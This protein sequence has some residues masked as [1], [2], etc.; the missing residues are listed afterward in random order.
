M[1]LV[2]ASLIIGGLLAAV[3]IALHLL[4]RPKPQTM[5]FPAVR[6]VFNRRE[7]NVRKLQ[8]RHWLLLALRCLIIVLLALSLAR[9]SVVAASYG[10]W[11]ASGFLFGLLLLF[12]TLS[13]AAHVH[14]KHR[15]I[16]IAM[17]AIT[18]LT[19]ILLST[20]ML[21][22]LR[23]R[24]ILLTGNRLAPVATALVIDT[25]L[26]MDYRARNQTRL[27]VACEIGHW[28]VNQLPQDSQ[29]AVLESRMPTGQNSQI[30]APS[31][32]LDL[33]GAKQAIER[34]Q[35]T[36]HTR[37]LWRVIEEGINLLGRSE[38][39]QQEIFVFTDFT[40]SAWMP[41]LLDQ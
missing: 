8:L 27:E 13:I 41:A 31:F 19:L 17:T 36:G 10:P 18:T 6:F 34:L 9:P 11:L 21:Y 14:Q 38:L 20:S 3:P 28:V 32:C 26:R 1:G 30:E 39:S 25:S 24:S 35:T 33:S 12:A 22:A 40:R 23:G 4:M 7:S 2:N 5:V 29:V 37:S 16:V 15:A